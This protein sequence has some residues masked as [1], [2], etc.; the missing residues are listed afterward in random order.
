MGFYVVFFDQRGSGL[1]KRHDRNIY[2]VQLMLDDITAVI[3]HYRR[4]SKQKIFSFLGIRGGQ[5]SPRP[6]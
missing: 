5:C 4:S 1:S 2:S 3:D 6:T